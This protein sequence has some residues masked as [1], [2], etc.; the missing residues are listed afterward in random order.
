MGVQFS[1]FFLG[2]LP[3]KRHP[4][5]ESPT[6][7][8]PAASYSAPEMPQLLRLLAVNWLPSFSN[9]TPS[10]CPATGPMAYWIDDLLLP[11]YFRLDVW[12]DRCSSVLVLDF[13]GGCSIFVGFGLMSFLDLVR[14]T[15]QTWGHNQSRVR[16]IS[17]NMRT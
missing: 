6:F 2:F 11:I 15:Q 13:C 10:H 7:P 16:G 9:S 1:R 5:W 8:A 17:T 3:N 14:T 4:S 12:G